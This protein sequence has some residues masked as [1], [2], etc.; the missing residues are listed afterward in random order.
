MR[1]K[2]PEVIVEPSPPPRSAT[3][4]SSSPG[5]PRSSRPHPLHRLAQARVG[6]GDFRRRPRPSRTASPSA[7]RLS[8]DPRDSCSERTG[9]SCRAPPSRTTPRRFWL[10]SRSHAP[11]APRSLGDWWGSTWPNATAACK[12]RHGKGPREDGA[13][14]LA[15]L[16]QRLRAS[17]RIMKLARRRC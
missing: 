10:D 3:T 4:S 15:E 9:P 7:P 13:T 8:S 12:Q 2:K 14:H 1:G 16:Q 6:R 5:H 17:L 11:P